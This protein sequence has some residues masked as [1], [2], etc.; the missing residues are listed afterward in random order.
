MLDGVL[1]LPASAMTDRQEIWFVDPEASAP[2][3]LHRLS[4]SPLFA[5]GGQV[6][7]PAPE[8][9]EALHVL[10]HPMLSYLEGMMVRTRVASHAQH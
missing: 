5:L 10:T 1:V 6:L 2:V 3:P 9:L 4:V 7:V 8:G